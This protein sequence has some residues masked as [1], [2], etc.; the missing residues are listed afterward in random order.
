M[1]KKI[2]IALVDD[3]PVI[4]LGLEHL[5]N[6]EED[7]EVVG[8]AISGNGALTILESNEVDVV[9]MDI[10]M[11]GMNGLDTAELIKQI[12]PEVKVIFITMYDSRDY[13][14]KAKEIGVEGYLI[15][16]DAPAVFKQAIRNVFNGFTD[17]RVKEEPTTFNY[18]SHILSLS[19]RETEIVG[20]IGQGET[21]KKIAEDLNISSR[22][23]D[24]HRVNI[25][26]K[27]K[28]KSSADFV[29][30]AIEHRL[31]DTNVVLTK[32]S[33]KK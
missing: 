20:L 22:T 33:E 24:C 1:D 2:R 18:K 9:V 14:A 12:K 19:K 13:I 8:K 28:L 5:I 17:Y 32:K 31:I 4:V 21:T 23:V 3:H 26:K 29:K 25:K 6:L 7:M 16:E 11:P 10:S 15:K 27:L 30:L